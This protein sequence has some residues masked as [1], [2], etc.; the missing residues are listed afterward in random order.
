MFDRI[1]NLYKLSNLDVTVDK[2][3]EVI[4]IAVKPEKL[5]PVQIIKINK[6]PVEEFIQS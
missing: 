4:D 1:K 6:D 3:K 5:P 2:D